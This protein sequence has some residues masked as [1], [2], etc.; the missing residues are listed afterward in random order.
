MDQKVVKSK[1]GFN[2]YSTTTHFGWCW[3]TIRFVVPHCYPTISLHIMHY[4][5]KHTR[6][7]L[8]GFWC[9]ESPVRPSYG[10]KNRSEKHTPQ[11][12]AGDQPTNHDQRWNGLIV[13]GKCTSMYQ[14]YP[15]MLPANAPFAHTTF[16]R[17][18]STLKRNIDWRVEGNLQNVS[19][20]FLGNQ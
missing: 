7:A 1:R 9:Q 2:Y 12:Q 13:N 18:P 16:A 14:Y 19:T 10:S 20:E 8:I 5:T 3:S 4:N 11:F 17:F 6:Y 15:V